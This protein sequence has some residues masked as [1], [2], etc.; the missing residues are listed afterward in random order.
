MASRGGTTSR[1]ISN[2]SHPAG[3]CFDG[4]SSIR[5]PCKPELA[6][7]TGWTSRQEDTA[8]AG[9]ITA[10]SH[11]VQGFQSG[12][13]PQACHYTLEITAH[14]KFPICSSAQRTR[15]VPQLLIVEASG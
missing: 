4:Q 1:H 10:E 6:P 9:R 13:Q 15:I 11:P 7:R 14:M 3:I 2:K 8:L 12:S 5:T